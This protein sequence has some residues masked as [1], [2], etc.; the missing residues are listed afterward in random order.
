M[1]LALL[2]VGE[3]G[4]IT[5]IRG[6]E[7]VVHHLHNL[8]FAAGTDVE[9]VGN[10]DAGMIIA[11]K[12]S[13]VALNRGMA[14]KITVNRYSDVY[15]D[16]MHAHSDKRGDK[17]MTLRN[18]GVGQTVTVSKITGVG[19]IKRRI[20]DMG[21]TKGTSVYVRKVAPLGDPIEVTVRGYELS[22]RKADAELIE[23]Q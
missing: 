2:G 8:G 4:T 20:M 12:G 22:L 15:I 7:D 11:V 6:K 3:S 23:V 10:T 9:V 13:R 5:D 1:P 17:A 19:A 14:S 18:V 21:L 16:R